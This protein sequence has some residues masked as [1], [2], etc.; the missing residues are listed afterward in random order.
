V[1]NVIVKFHIET[2][3]L[4]TAAGEL[5]DEALSIQRLHD[6][7][8][9]CR[10]VIWVD[11]ADRDSVATALEAD[12]TVDSPSHLGAEGDGHWYAIETTDAPLHAVSSGLLTARGMLV[13]ADWSQNRW[14]G[15]ARFPDRSS[16]LTF[17]EELVADGFDVA[18]EQIHE[19]DDALT[20]F[21]VTDPQREV[22]LLALDRG[23]YT[24]PRD[25]SLSDLASDLG[26]SS[27][28]ASERLRRGTQTLVANTLAAPARTSL[29]S[30]SH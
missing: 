30:Q 19:D 27:Q 6:F 21:G 18:V 5:P 15:K 14:V 8:G 9:N 23:Y 24:V 20:Q 17:R 29:G 22:L 2:G 13:R 4:R 1:A 16:L 28:A 12:E 25:A 7:E 11:V 10:V 3:F 26:I